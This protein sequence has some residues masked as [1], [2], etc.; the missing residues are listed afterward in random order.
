MAWKVVSACNEMELQP[1]LDELQGRVPSQDEHG[2]FHIVG[3]IAELVS[4]GVQP[5]GTIVVAARVEV[6][7]DPP[8]PAK[9]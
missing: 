8:L 6:R 5:G 7:R 9:A 3:T 4:L 2:D 1:K